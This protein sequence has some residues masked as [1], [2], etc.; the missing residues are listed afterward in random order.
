MNRPLILLKNLA[1]KKIEIRL[2]QRCNARK[3]LN[4]LSLYNN[5]SSIEADIRDVTL[6]L[7]NDPNANAFNY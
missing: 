6:L 2:A 7:F 5:N 4:R 3:Q 1:K